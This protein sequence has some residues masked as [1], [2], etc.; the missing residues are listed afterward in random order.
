MG[1]TRCGLYRLFYFL[2]FVT[3]IPCGLG[4]GHVSPVSSVLFIPT[5]VREGVLLFVPSRLSVKTQ[6]PC[7]LESF[8]PTVGFEFSLASAL[9]L[10]SSPHLLTP[11]R[12]P[13]HRCPP[14]LPFCFASFSPQSSPLLLL[15]SV[16]SLCALGPLC[17]DDVHIYTVA[18]MA[19]LG[20]SVRWEVR[21]EAPVRS[22][23]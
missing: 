23:G 2:F 11:A 4:P 1:L 20:A 17:W 8:F 18:R 21:E 5:T 9:S 13:S 16:P 6:T 14:F 12:P 7:K 19:A 3:F 22:E 15:H 10:V